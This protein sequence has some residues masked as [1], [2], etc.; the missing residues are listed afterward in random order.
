MAENP[1]LAWELIILLRRYREKAE[2]AGVPREE[3][4]HQFITALAYGVLHVEAE[5]LV[6]RGRVEEALRI[7]RKG[8]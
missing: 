4:E 8:P 1:S 2:A 5:H 3:I 7:G 6:E